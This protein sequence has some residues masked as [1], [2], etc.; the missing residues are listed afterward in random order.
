MAEFRSIASATGS[1]TGAKPL[2]ITLR[3]GEPPARPQRSRSRLLVRP[4]LLRRDLRPHIQ[5]LEGFIRL[6]EGIADDPL[7]ESEAKL[8]HLD[9][10]ERALTE[11][12][13][14]RGYLKPGL[15]LRD[16]LQASGV[17]DRHAR[18]ILQAFRKDAAGQTCRTWSDLLLYCRYAAAPVGRYML[19]LH[20]EKAADATAA[21][22]ALCAAVQ[23]LASLQDC[24]SDWV[25]LGRSYVPLQW[26]DEAGIS[27]ERLVETVSDSSL[28]GVF[29]RLLRQVDGLLARSASL[30]QLMSDRPLRMETATAHALAVALRKRLAVADP[31]ARRV[32]VPFGARLTARAIGIIQGYGRH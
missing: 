4:R 6:A 16:S 1:G 31:L 19:E 3:P 24:R 27:A 2:P 23:I 26:F 20:R 12:K 18:Q 5:A 9:A 13:A 17:S 25:D 30:P 28:R 7:M 29:D 10:L 14:R 8:H 15:D 22:D 21:S 32:T 11:G